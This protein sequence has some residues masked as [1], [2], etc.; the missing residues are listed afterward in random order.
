[1]VWLDLLPMQLA[2]AAEPCTQ[3][4]MGDICSDSGP[5][6]EGTSQTVIGI[7]WANER[8]GHVGL[9]IWSL[10]QNLLLKSVYMD[11]IPF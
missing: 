8:A 4:T 10:C 7:P 6:A 5:V 1:M 3:K 2:G 11:K 9:I